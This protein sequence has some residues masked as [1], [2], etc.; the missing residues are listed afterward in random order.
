MASQINFG[1][2]PDTIR[3]VSRAFLAF[4]GEFRSA[5]REKRTEVAQFFQDI[6]ECLAEVTASLRDDEI[7]HGK[8]GE[9]QGFA[10]QLPEK[11]T[12]VIK[13]KSEVE[14][15]ADLLGQ[16]YEVESLW[17]LFQDLPNREEE[18]A[19]L[20]EASGKFRGLAVAI[21]PV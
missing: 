3:E 21:R 15:L 11:V 7:P 2:I 10:M 6:S 20:D 12:G 1:F 16:A 13:E 5:G 17:G 4:R 9:M 19:K 14:H 8:C 18:L